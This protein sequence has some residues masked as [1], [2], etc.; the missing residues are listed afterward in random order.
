MDDHPIASDDPIGDRFVIMGCLF[1]AFP[2]VFAAMATAFFGWP[3][4]A[5]LFR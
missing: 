5:Y 4:I 3:F 1:L 2:C